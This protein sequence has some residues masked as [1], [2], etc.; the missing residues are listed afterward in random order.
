MVLYRRK[1][2][3]VH[4]PYFVDL[5]HGPKG[6]G[7]VFRVIERTRPR[8]RL[9]SGGTRTETEL[10]LSDEA[11]RD[12]QV[13][14]GVCRPRMQPKSPPPAAPARLA[15]CGGCGTA[16]FPPSLPRQ[17]RQVP[18]DGVRHEYGASLA[19]GG[20]LTSRPCCAVT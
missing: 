7:P 9:R 18:P 16:R 15:P 3:E 1:Y 8:S 2:Q 6:P 17:L 19:G 20:D 12:R 14:R 10:R 4:F 13:L 5:L 11:E